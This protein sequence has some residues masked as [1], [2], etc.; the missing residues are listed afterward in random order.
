MGQIGGSIVIGDDKSG[1]EQL[2][3][4]YWVKLRCSQMVATNTIS[5]CV[6]CWSW[7]AEEP[8]WVGFELLTP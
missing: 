8:R 5:A 4:S 1:G 3:V 6:E 7:P 2:N